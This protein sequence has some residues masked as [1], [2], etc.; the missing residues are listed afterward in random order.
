MSSLPL[1]IR[2]LLTAGIGMVPIIELRGA[3]PIGVFTFHLNYIEAF[4]CSFVGN[5]IPVYFI[6]KFI[7]PLF[8][9]FGRWKIFKVIIDWATEKATKHIQEDAKLQNA[10]SFG[11]FIFVAIPLPGTGAWVGSLI[12]NFLGLPPKK[13]IPP[14]VAGV[15]TAGVIVLTL[16]AI[17][18]GGIQYLLQRI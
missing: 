12:A 1:M 13:A 2:Y 5:I 14:I 16:T 8:D 17:A 3:I 15:F 9:F 11:L 4:L 6:V 7:R 10:V 18:N